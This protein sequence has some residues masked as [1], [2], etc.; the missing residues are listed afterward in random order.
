MPAFEKNSKSPTSPILDGTIDMLLNYESMDFF[1]RHT[2]IVQKGELC[3]TVL[4][5]CN[6]AWYMYNVK[7]L[8]FS[9][10]FINRCRIFKAMNCCNLI[11]VTLC[12]NKL[13]NA[14]FENLLQ[15]QL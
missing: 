5:H 1:S 7:F 4:S 12:A 15:L 9:D 11:T 14:R 10:L 3:I 13:N 6:V 8:S 2:C